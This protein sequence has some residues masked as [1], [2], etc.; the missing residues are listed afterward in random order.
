[1]IVPTVASD[2]SPVFQVVESSPDPL[3]Y[4]DSP[5]PPPRRKRLA[6]GLLPGDGTY[7]KETAHW[8]MW[9]ARKYADDPRYDLLK[10]IVHTDTPADMVRNRIVRDAQAQGAD[11][12]LMVDSD[13]DPDYYWAVER[14]PEARPFVPSSLEFLEK[15]D[16]PAVI[17]AP[18]CGPPPNE[19]VYVF[20]WK[21]GEVSHDFDGKLQM[22]DRTAAAMHRGVTQVAALPTGLILFDM[23]VFDLLP[24]PWFYY[25]YKDQYRTHKAST[26]DVTFSRDCA[27]CRIPIYCN[28]DAWARHIKTKAVGRP[29]QQ[30]VDIVHPRISRIVAAGWEPGS[31]VVDA[32]V[33]NGF[34]P[35]WPS[36]LP[37][38]PA[39]ESPTAVLPITPG[40]VRGEI[41][42]G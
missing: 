35:D 13:M 10:P 39:G 20:E 38:L 15:L 19:Y 5:P 11:L 22:Y 16:R 18:Y 31:A 25:E 21:W 34:G 28:W 37:T 42:V 14:S 29:Q 32:G 24:P 4:G 27:L 2:I 12:L 17:A 9:L 8:L 41:I 7:R 40:A 23:R 6:L 3:P 33:L 36:H 26:E 30:T 1:M